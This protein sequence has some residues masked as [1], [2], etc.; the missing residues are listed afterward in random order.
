MGT[1]H[2]GTKKEKRALDLFIKLA[3]ASESVMAAAGGAAREA[4][5]SPSQ[6]GALETLYHLGPMCQKELGSKMLKSGGNITTVVDNLERRGLARRARDGKDR[7]YITVSLTPKGSRLIGRL[8]PRVLEEVVSTV[9]SLAPAEQEEASRLLRKLGLG[10][11]RR[12][13]ERRLRRL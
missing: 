1:H 2:K 8:F 12:R 10:A 9:S 13:G 4:G 5:L 7:R 11:A 6:F 3:R